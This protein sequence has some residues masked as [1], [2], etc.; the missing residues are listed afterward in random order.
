[1]SIE[2]HIET[3]AGRRV[4][5]FGPPP[6]GHDESPGEDPPG[7]HDPAKLAW[8]VRV[9]PWAD[10]EEPF[11]ERFGRFLATVDPGTVEALIIG[12]WGDELFQG[13]E[14]N[15]DGPLRLLTGAADRLTALEALFFGEMILEEAEISWIPQTNVTPLLGA[16]PRL[17]HLRVRGADGLALDAV[18]H[19]RLVELAFEAGGLPAAVVRSLGASELP[20]LERLE[21]WLGTPEYGGDSRV[22]DLA[23]VL[24]GAR[25]PNLRYLGLRNSE[26]ADQVAAAIATAPV[27]ERL[28]ELDL[29]LGVLTDAGAEALLTGQPLTHLRRLDLHHHYLSDELAGRL[30]QQLAST[31][32]EVDLSEQE[33]AGEDDEERYVAV[34]E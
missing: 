10:G 20:S 9:E 12:A 13:S 31:G 24:D 5:D 17:R 14:D 8:R 22:E 3:F 7:G 28:E 2:S 26:M 30:R 29:S 21:L 1:M 16:F 19:E 33:D 32:V 6:E 25:L 11:E 4:V 27:V 34:G 15:A 23:P 18:R